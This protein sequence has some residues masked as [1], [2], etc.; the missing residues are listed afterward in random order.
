MFWERR[1]L[2]LKKIVCYDFL[3]GNKSYKAFGENSQS[4]KAFGENSGSNI[5]ASGK[6]LFLFTYFY[7]EGSWYPYVLL[8]N[9]IEKRLY[10]TKRKYPDFTA[11]TILS[12]I[13]GF[14]TKRVFHVFAPSDGE[15]N[16]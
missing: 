16:Y 3:L 4:Y 2:G 5:Q 13:R 11:L 12:K 15:N 10:F 7:S 8:T 14:Q 6:A 9:I 1:V